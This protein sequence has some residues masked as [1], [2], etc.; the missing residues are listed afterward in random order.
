MW[1]DPRPGRPNS[2]AAGK[3]PL[4]NMCPTIVTH[5][6]QRT[7]LGASGGRRIMPAV[8]QLLSFLVDYKM[9]FQPG[10]RRFDMGES[11]NFSALPMAV[12]A[13]EQLLEWGVDNIQSTLT[14]MTD[15]IAE[16]AAPLGLTASDPK[17]RAGHFLGL[18]F[19]GEIPVSLTERLAEKNVFVSVRGQSM[20]VTPH[21]YND[22]KDIER[23]IFA[24]A[25]VV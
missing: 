20:R 17:D 12:A 16:Q 10:A 23:L 15:R 5:D 7:A 13:L 3:R 9:D 22:D 24:L 2:I 14:N 19:P 18:G 6:S 11:A 1:F 4:S 25:S 21:L 8:F